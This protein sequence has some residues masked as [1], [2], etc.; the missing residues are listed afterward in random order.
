MKRKENKG[1]EVRKG[2]R[3]RGV[4]EKEEGWGRGQPRKFRPGS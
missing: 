2:G 4:L 1:R 3:G